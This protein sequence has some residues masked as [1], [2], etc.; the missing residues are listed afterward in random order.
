MRV[1]F[2]TDW[3]DVPLV[4]E[5]GGLWP[6]GHHGR[7]LVTSPYPAKTQLSPV[8][9]EVGPFSDCGG[10]SLPASPSGRRVR[11]SVWIQEMDPTLIL[12]Q[13][14]LA[15]TSAVAWIR[16]RPATSVPHAGWVPRAVARHRDQIASRSIG[17]GHYADPPPPDLDAKAPVGR[18]IGL[19]TPFG[20]QHHTWPAL[21]ASAA[22]APPNSACTPGPPPDNNL[23]L[24]PELVL[25]WAGHCWHDDLQAT[26]AHTDSPAE[27]SAA[28][29]FPNSSS[30]SS[31]LNN[32]LDA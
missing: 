14:H 11:R 12:G 27:V 24:A 31:A 28:G 6:S 2:L 4:A 21:S 3:H 15:R 19:L 26:L 7:V 13:L 22:P 10:W 32:A 25:C 1:G 18:M 23:S 16:G 30:T 8:V 5:V 20:S 17:I 29:T 9:V